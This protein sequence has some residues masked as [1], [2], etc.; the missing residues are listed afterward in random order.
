MPTI[1]SY[2]C[3]K[4][5]FLS[6][7]LHKFVI[8]LLLIILILLRLAWVYYELV[9]TFCSSSFEVVSPEMNQ[10]YFCA[11]WLRR[12]SSELNHITSSSSDATKCR[13][14]H[15]PHNSLSNYFLHFRFAR[16][17]WNSSLLLDSSFFFLLV[18]TI[19]KF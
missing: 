6:Y 11:P 4:L 10:A 12:V 18:G 15:R 2:F 8:N 5:T 17:S 3:F 16:A 14:T 7:Y 13:G 1:T 9:S 19:D